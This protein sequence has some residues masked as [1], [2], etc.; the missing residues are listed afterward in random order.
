MEQISIFDLDE[1]LPIYKI[2]RNKTIRL[3]SLFSGY[4]SQ[5]LAFN[6]LDIDVEHYRAVEFDKYAIQSLNEIHNTNFPILDITHIKGG[7]LGIE[8][9]DK[10]TYVMTYSFPCTDLSLAGKR[11]GMEK[12]SNTRSGLL[13]EVE[14][15]LNEVDNLPQILIM[16][17]VPQVLTSNGWRDWV[18]FLERKGYS[19]YAEILNAKNYG[20]PQN[21][22]RCFM[23]S[24]LGKY[25]YKFPKGFELK[26]RLKDLLECEVDESY[27]LSDKF[28]NYCL[29]INQK[30]S[31]FPRA[32]RFI[33][34]LTMTNDKEIATAIS[35]NAGNR[36]VDNFILVPEATKQGF[37]FAGDGDGDGVY[38]DRPHQ[39]RGVVQKGMIQT[40]KTSCFDVGVVVGST[41]KNAYIGSI[42]KESPSLTSAMGMGGGHIPM[43]IKNDNEPK[44]LDGIGEKK[45]NGG[46]QWYQQDRIYD[47]NVA[48]SV[49]TSF[50]PNNLAGNLRIR[51]LTPKEC[52]KLMGVKPSDYEKITVSKSKK[53]KQAGNSIVTTCLMAIYSQLFNNID[54]KKKIDELVE[55]LIE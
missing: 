6:Y 35:T 17:N 25:N 18:S 33:E 22:E 21:R 34:S 32:K 9:T 46:T 54:Y 31:K 48:I 39:K 16:E 14:R 42:D 51:K 44:V 50:Q 36:P 26:Y 15:L 10:Y 3:I 1:E 8:D 27:Y 28:L 47:N 49:T 37:S 45:S 7:Y 13:W 30:P 41:Q 24:I 43:I 19:N 20:I 2:D 11:A 29:G 52:F 40:L 38:I 4:D 12:G 53:Y 5:K 55:E 23:V